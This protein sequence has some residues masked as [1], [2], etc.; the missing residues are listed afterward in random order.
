MWTRV[1]ISSP[2]F[3][4]VATQLAVKQVSSI[5]SSILSPIPLDFRLS[6]LLSFSKIKI[7]SLSYCSNFCKLW[8]Q[9]SLWIIKESS[10]VFSVTWEV[11]CRVVFMSSSWSARGFRSCPMLSIIFDSGLSSEIKIIFEEAWTAMQGQ[12]QVV[13]HFVFL[14][15]I[16]CFWAS[17]IC[18]LIIWRKLLSFLWRRS[19]FLS[20]GSFH[21]L[22]VF[23]IYSNHRLFQYREKRDQEL[24]THVSVILVWCHPL[25]ITIE[26]QQALRNNS[27]L[28]FW[29]HNLEAYLR[30][31]EWIH[32]ILV[33]LR[34][35]PKKK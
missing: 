7:C 31:S 2:R 8:K 29:C 24:R 32:F 33:K 13:S 20:P 22:I 21:R 34:P 6:L 10:F 23:N 14:I 25:N 12:R 4:S 5:D 3:N 1:S 15:C 18:R 26:H 17:L 30:D 11:Y 16:C 28:Y 19:I 9:T 35:M 27:R